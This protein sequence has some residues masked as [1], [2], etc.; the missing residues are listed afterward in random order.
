MAFLSITVKNFRN[1]LD[2][3]I[4]LAYPEIFLI[5]KNGQGKTNLLETIYLLSYGNSF[6]TKSDADLCKRGETEF[7]LSALYKADE[8]M[9][10]TLSIRSK[11]RKKDI[12]KNGKKITDRK[13]LIST[14]PCIIFC[15]DDIAF[16][17]GEM[18]KRRFF[19]DQTL[20]LIDAQYIDLLRTFNKVL[21]IRN[22][23]LKNR[24]LDILDSLDIQLSES[25]LQIIKLRKAL[26]AEINFRFEEYY[27]KISDIENVHLEYRTNWKADNANDI[28]AY[29]LQHRQNDI[30]FGTTMSGPQ[31][32][33]VHYVCGSSLFIPQA[34]TGQ[35]RLISLVLRAIQ[36]QCYVQKSQRKPVLLLDDVLLELDTEKKTKFME[37]LPQYDQLFC[38]FLPGEPIDNYKTPKTKVYYVDNGEFLN[39]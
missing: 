6:R 2:K 11:D 39:E 12:Y 25:G 8:T 26:I 37:L 4:D 28:L 13:Q 5:G 23:C 21:K 7:L 3:T 24:Q 16:A 27:Y 36:A 9:S 34:S 22:A 10:H 38:T 19:L 32:D 30:D 31:R 17:N 1:L 18:Q 15:H 14:V 35:I 29:L 33:K 20:T